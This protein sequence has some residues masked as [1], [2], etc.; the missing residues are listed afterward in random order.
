MKDKSNANVSIDNIYKLDG[1]VPVDKAIPFGLQHVLAM[2]VS[3]LAPIIIVVGA[4]QASHPEFEID[5]PMLIQNAMF[6]AGLGTMVQLYP[7]WKI[8]ARLP[9]VMGVS[10]TFL[11]SLIYVATNFATH[12]PADLA[13]SLRALAD[14]SS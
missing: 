11:A 3:N 10:F 12:R 9:V 7:I 5:L 2:F 1:R 13:T 4:T 6:V 8:G 14:L